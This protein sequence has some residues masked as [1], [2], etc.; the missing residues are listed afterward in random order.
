MTWTIARIQSKKTGSGQL[1]LPIS[2]MIVVGSPFPPPSCGRGPLPPTPSHKACFLCLAST[3]VCT[4]GQIDLTSKKQVGLACIAVKRCHVVLSS[5]SWHPRSITSHI[6][7]LPI[8]LLPLITSGRENAFL[9]RRRCVRSS[10]S[11][12]L[13]HP[14]SALEARPGCPN[15]RPHI[16][17]LIRL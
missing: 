7:H 12:N 2:E 1:G 5:F 3:G 13:R 16:I 15:G 8:K 11:G 6:V 14:S 9:V 4:P 10:S 17:S